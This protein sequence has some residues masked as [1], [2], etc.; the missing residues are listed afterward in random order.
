MV[1]NMCVSVIIPVYNA[2]LY[3]KR[4]LDSIR[5]QDYSDYEVLLIDDGSTDNSAQICQEY[6]ASDSRFKY[7]YQDNQGPDMARKKGTENASGDYLVYVDSD[8]YIALNMLSRMTEEINETGADVV[9]A[10]IVRFNEKKEWISEKS[11][12]KRVVLN[13]KEDILKAFFIDGIIIGSYCAKI[14]KKDLI[15]DYE[16]VRDG[17]IGEDVSAALHIYCNAGKITV[18]PDRL[19]YYYQNLDS[20][21]HHKYTPRH[22]VSLNN[23]VV[24]RD[25]FLDMR[26]VPDSRICGYFAGYEMAVAT[27]MGRSGKYI[28]ESGEILRNDLKAHFGCIMSDRKTGFIMKTCILMYVI[29]PKLFIG[30]YRILYLLTGR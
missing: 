2:G 23:Y 10:Q 27:A 22:A 12:Q 17:F 1:N 30:L 26:S 3:L 4:C 8:D 14:I 24:V 18:I 6:V 9:C 21:S 25:H 5:S 7:L 29:C 19:Y 28:P 13:G 20:I 11:T 16:F 15:S